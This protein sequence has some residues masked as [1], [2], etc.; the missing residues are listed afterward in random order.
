MLIEDKI[1]A[2]LSAWKASQI[3][4]PRNAYSYYINLLLAKFSSKTN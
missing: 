1:K 3:F 4:A 2:K